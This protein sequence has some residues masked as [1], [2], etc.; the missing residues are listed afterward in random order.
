LG[1]APTGVDGR[2]AAAGTAKKRRD[3]A[4]PAG[5]WFPCMTFTMVTAAGMSTGDRII[6]KIMNGTNMALPT[7]LCEGFGWMCCDT[8]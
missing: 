2:Q 7:F 3:A 6:R 1:A 5:R 8:C 4:A